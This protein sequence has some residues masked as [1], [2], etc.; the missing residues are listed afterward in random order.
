MSFILQ[1][2][3]DPIS[4][5]CHMK[6]PM[7]G[8][9]HASAPKCLLGCFSA[10]TWKYIDMWWHV[11]SNIY[12]FLSTCQLCTICLFRC[13]L[14]NSM[15]LWWISIIYLNFCATLLWLFMWHILRP[16]V[17][18][19]IDILTSASTAVLLFSYIY[20]WPIQLLCSSTWHQHHFAAVTNFSIL[21]FFIH[22][23]ASIGVL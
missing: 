7:C 23:E 15:L 10:L 14:S 12:T 6:K 4:S 13:F 1:K 21:S 18:L 16:F 20:K 11:I 22:L 2:S 8:T 19:C 5:L 9:L 17:N 3:N